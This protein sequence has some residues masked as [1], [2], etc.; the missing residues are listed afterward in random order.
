MYDY[1]ALLTEGGARVFLH[2]D[3]FDCIDEG[4]V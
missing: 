4:L 1:R 2:H 3:A